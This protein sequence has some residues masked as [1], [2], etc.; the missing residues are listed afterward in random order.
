MADDS[1]ILA[2]KRAP[3]F[4]VWTR[5]LIIQEVQI[6]EYTRRGLDSLRASSIHKIGGITPSLYFYE[7]ENALVTEKGDTFGIQETNKTLGTHF[8]S[9]QPSEGRRIESESSMIQC[10]KGLV[11]VRGFGDPLCYVERDDI[12][13]YSFH[14][15]PLITPVMGEQL[16]THTHTNALM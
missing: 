3:L 13:A 15:L 9:S 1:T 14:Y 16:Q 10:L 2:G 11:R 7:L 4:T 5:E 12:Q 6:H 8:I